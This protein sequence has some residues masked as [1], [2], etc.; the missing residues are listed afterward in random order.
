M[1]VGVDAVLDD[2]FVVVDVEVEVDVFDE[3]E[4]EEVV[5][6]FVD[7]VVVE[8]LRLLELEDIGFGVVM[9]EE[10]VVTLG[11]LPAQS[12]GKTMQA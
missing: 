2:V 4:E 9:A 12:A 11:V 8:V 3:E 1:T 7:V 5:T 10:V 6:G